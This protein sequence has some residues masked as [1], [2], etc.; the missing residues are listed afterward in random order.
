M[1][2]SAPSFEHRHAEEIEDRG[3]GEVVNIGV[4]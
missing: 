4:R 1:F 3:D 2:G